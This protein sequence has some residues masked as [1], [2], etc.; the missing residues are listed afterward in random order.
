MLCVKISV[1]A[2]LNEVTPKFVSVIAG[3]ASGVAELSSTLPDVPPYPADG[4]DGEACC[5]PA[6]VIEIAKVCT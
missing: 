5:P 4:A 2:S 1:P 6:P 3:L